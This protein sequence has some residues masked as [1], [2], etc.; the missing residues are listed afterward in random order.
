[1][2][3]GGGEC[4]GENGKWR[5]LFLRRCAFAREKGESDEQTE[6]QR[7]EQRMKIGVMEGEEGGRTGKFAQRVDVGD[8]ACDEHGDRA[9]SRD[10]RKRGPF[11]GVGGE[12]VGEGVHGEGYLMNGD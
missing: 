7:R 12:R 9:G 4:S 3:N 6:Q 2:E 11:E 8:A 1:M 10:A 5:S